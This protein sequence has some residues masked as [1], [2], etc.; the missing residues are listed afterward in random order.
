ML[1]E[2]AGAKPAVRSSPPFFASKK[3]DCVSAAEEGI[4]S[5]AFV[6]TFFS[7]IKTVLTPDRCGDSAA[8]TE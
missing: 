4:G 3:P 1:D 6:M 7:R 8:S 2:T 5:P